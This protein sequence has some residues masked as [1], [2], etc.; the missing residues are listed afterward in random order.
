ME[1]YKHP[2]LWLFLLTL[3]AIVRGGWLAADYGSLRQDPDTYRQLA[4][5]LLSDGT[6]GY[7][8]PGDA[9]TRRLQPTAYRPPLYPLVLAA[10]GWVDDVGVASIAIL[11]AVAGIATVLLVY[12]LSQAWE[13]G[14]WGFWAAVLTACDPI[15]L[16]QSSRVMTETLATLLAVLGLLGL[17]RL[18]VVST[19]SRAS[20]AGALVA[21][22]A[23]CRPTFLVWGAAAAVAI[24]LTPRSSWRTR[25]WLAGSFVL[26][27]VVMMAPWTVRNALAFG[28][29]IV[30]TTHGG[31]T[32]WLGNNE[33]FYSFLDR[34][35]WGEVWGSQQLDEQYLAI[36]E[37][38]NFDE[39]RVDR[40]AYDQGVASIRRH[41]ASFLRACV[42]RVGSLWG[43]V[44]QQIEVGESVV[45]RVA[46][47]AVGAWYAVVFALT[48]W[49]VGSLGRRLCCQPW[50]WGLLLCLSFTAMHVVYWSNLRMRAPLVPVVCLAAAI[51]V[52]AIVSRTLRW[53][54][55]RREA[56][57]SRT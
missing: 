52:R 31:Y 35:G 2:R 36:R 46:R 9:G 25:V 40:W 54:A 33:E 5:H 29:P 49:G 39:L 41:P 15:L 1:R 6:F 10:C 18:T 3:A 23:L 17:T 28:R 19:A 16:N 22:A 57:P 14:R 26:A 53:R 50:L 27:G 4:R 42:F 7:R 8:I 47:Y 38:Y 51:G 13:L 34:A 44:P 21:L 11:H 32:L 48:L 30:T 45:K 20:L 55:A 24:L 37:A 12:R 43:L 56:T